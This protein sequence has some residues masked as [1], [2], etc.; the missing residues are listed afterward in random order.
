MPW[1]YT[2]CP[3]EECGRQ[4]AHDSNGFQGGILAMNE[5][6]TSQLEAAAREAAEQAL[7]IAR[8][9]LAQVKAELESARAQAAT[10]TAEREDFMAALSHELRTPLNPVLLIASEA[11]ENAALPEA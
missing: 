7:K 9:E 3:W 5:S 8:E 1:P 4:P 11:A 2:A 10:T 6:E